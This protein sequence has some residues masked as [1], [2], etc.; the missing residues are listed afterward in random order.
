M[1]IYLMKLKHTYLS[2]VL[3]KP[4]AYTQPHAH[5]NWV[6]MARI[7]NPWHGLVVDFEVKAYVGQSTHHCQGNFDLWNIRSSS[8]RIWNLRKGS[9]IVNNESSVIIR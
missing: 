5:T 3:P 6:P 7:I 1:M 8:D 9:L 2:P 4:Q